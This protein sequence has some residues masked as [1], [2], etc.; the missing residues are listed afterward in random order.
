MASLLSSQHPHAIPIHFSLVYSSVNTRMRPPTRSTRS[1]R[2]PSD[3]RSTNPRGNRSETS[4]PPNPP[5]LQ[6]N[7]STQPNRSQSQATVA[8]AAA[9]TNVDS[10]TSSGGSDLAPMLVLGCFPV[11]PSPATFVFENQRPEPEA[12]TAPGSNASALGKPPRSRHR[13]TSGKLETLDA[14]FRHNTHPSRKEKEAI[15]K[16]LDM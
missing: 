8:A 2:P 6:P 10:S 1:I 13:M 11:L 14:F 7:L 16:D 15:C 3:R 5:T 4:N 12:Q 9:E